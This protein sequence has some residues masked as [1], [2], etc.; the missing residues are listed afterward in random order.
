MQPLDQVRRCPTSVV[1]RRNVSGVGHNSSIWEAAPFPVMADIIDV[2]K[3]AGGNAREAKTSAGPGCL[4]GLS[5]LTSEQ[6]PA[7]GPCELAFGD[8]FCA[9]NCPRNGAS[10]NDLHGA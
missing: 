4:N 2:P 3:I 9:A 6:S 8:D 1:M 5:A 7:V 10:P